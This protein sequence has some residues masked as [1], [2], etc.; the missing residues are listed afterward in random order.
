M[1]IQQEYE[2]EP[3]FPFIQIFDNLFSSSKKSFEASDSGSPCCTPFRAVRFGEGKAEQTES[4]KDT[5]SEGTG[6]VFSLMT[7][8]LR[9]TEQTGHCVVT[10]ASH[11]EL[12][13]A[14]A[15][16]HLPK[17]PWCADFPI[18]GD[19]LLRALDK[20]YSPPFA[21]RMRE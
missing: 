19:P 2:A 21:L 17:R 18:A 3:S 14:M 9:I 10:V 11:S 5:R 20:G 4:D 1:Q 6:A 15:A 16:R 13:D 7:T 12:A 8:Y